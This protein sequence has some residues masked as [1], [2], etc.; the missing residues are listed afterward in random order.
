MRAYLI[1]IFFIVSPLAYAQQTNPLPVVQQKIQNLNWLTG[2]WQGKAYVKGRDGK[3]QEMKHTLEFAD[4]LDNT[5][6]QLN[7]TLIGG[8][9]TV[10]HNI[11]LLGYDVLQSRYRLQAYT[12]DGSYIDAY[13]EAP[14]EKI[15]WRI[16]VPGHI[17]RY[18][19]KLNEK[20]QWY[21][22]GEVS[23][24]EGNTWNPF[25]ESTLSRKE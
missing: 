12:K 14:D 13:V 9:D 16:H 1:L 15:S 7:E 17:L 2:K 19:A 10:A 22:A 20:G 18:T 6:L 11:G 23:A 3:E 8:E 21:Q 4:K 25:F 5:V 24:D